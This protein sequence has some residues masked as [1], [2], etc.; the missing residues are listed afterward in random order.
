MT[1]CLSLYWLHLIPIEEMIKN[2][3]KVGKL[4]TSEWDNL[5]VGDIRMCLHFPFPF[6]KQNLTS[7]KINS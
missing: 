6:N 2:Q 3:T 1:V 7:Y 4:L 5:I